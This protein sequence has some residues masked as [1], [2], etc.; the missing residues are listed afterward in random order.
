M[1]FAVLKVAALWNLITFAGPHKVS[2]FSLPTRHVPRLSPSQTGWTHLISWLAPCRSA[3]WLALTEN[4][5]PWSW[6]SW[7]TEPFSASSQI[8]WSHPTSPFV[9]PFRFTSFALSARCRSR[10]SVYFRRQLAA[11]DGSGL[12]TTRSSKPPM[13]NKWSWMVL[14]AMKEGNSM[15]SRSDISLKI[16]FC[17]FFIQIT[18]TL[19]ESW[20]YGIVAHTFDIRLKLEL[21]KF[22]VNYFVEEFICE[23]SRSDGVFSHKWASRYTNL[24]FSS[25]NI[26]K[27]N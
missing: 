6:T 18:N 4:Q 3:P 25:F 5:R 1:E 12:S 7:H 19:C 24:K 9:S 22:T 26:H 2:Q 21:F 10:Y 16:W 23:T 20:T 15:T 8:P 14:C 17:L 13:C 11:A 27:W